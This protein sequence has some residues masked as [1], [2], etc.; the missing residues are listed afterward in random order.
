MQRIESKAR[1][2]VFREAFICAGARV[3][4]Q[5]GAEQRR[6]LAFG[7]AAVGVHAFLYIYIC[8]YIYTYVYIYI[9]IYV[10]THM[11]VYMYIYIYT[12]RERYVDTYKYMLLS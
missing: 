12:E 9:Y 1:S 3:A 10:Y 7:G 4:G 2:N 5:H 8:I 6:S 11:C